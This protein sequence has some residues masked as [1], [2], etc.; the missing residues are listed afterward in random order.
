MNLDPSVEL[1]R[2]IFVRGPDQQAYSGAASW[3][4]VHRVTAATKSSA[5]YDP[6]SK[7]QQIVGATS[8]SFPLRPKIDHTSRNVRRTS[9]PARDIDFPDFLVRPDR[10]PWNKAISMALQLGPH[11]DQ[12]RIR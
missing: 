10:H 3:T 5:I 7:Q 12:A 9:L 1:E 4:V 8:V 6:E 2:R 11:P